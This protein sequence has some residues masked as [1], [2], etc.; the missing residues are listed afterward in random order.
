MPG[1]EVGEPGAALGVIVGLDVH[2]AA[3]G[4]L[5]GD[6]VP[7]VLGNEVDGEEVDFLRGVDG[8]AADSALA[9]AAGQT[10]VV[11]LMPAEIAGGLNLDAPARA[12][13]SDEAVVGVV[14]AQR[15]GHLQFLEEAVGE[16]VGLADEAK[17]LARLHKFS[18]FLF[19]V[20]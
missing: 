1:F 6:D 7:G 5:N 18:H 2:E 13:L 20:K 16:E 10:D 4:D 3:V 14:F 19:T 15:L 11:G 17:T 9:G 8:G 12:E